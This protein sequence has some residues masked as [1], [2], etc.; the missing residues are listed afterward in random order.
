[1]DIINFVFFKLFDDNNDE[2]VSVD[3][4]RL[5]YRCYL[6]EFKFFKDENRFNEVVDIFLQGFF[7]I[8]NAQQQQQ[9]ILSNSSIKSISF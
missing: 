5:F 2:K 7:P 8:N 1:M 9:Q 6:P 4:I 3:E